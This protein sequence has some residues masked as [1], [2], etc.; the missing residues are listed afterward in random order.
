MLVPRVPLPMALSL[1]LTGCSGDIGSF[2]WVDEVP[3]AEI[4]AAA[5]GDYLIA[6]GDLLNVRVYNQD[7]LST[8]GRVRPDGRIG[9]PLAGEIEALGRRPADLAK[10]LEARLKPFILAP[11]VVVGVEEIQPIRITVLGEV[12]H[13][14]V[15]L[16]EPG[17]GVLQ[18]LASAG[19]TTEFADRDR[20]FVIRRRPAKEPLKIRFSYARLYNGARAPAFALATGDVVTVE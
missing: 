7:A 1:V 8:R 5:A 6:E 13:P 9:V 3:R 19:G 12:G 17:A 11:A 16:V 4:A 15:F 14:G 10:E 2:T 18:A 20:I